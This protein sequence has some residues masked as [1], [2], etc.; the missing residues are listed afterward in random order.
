MT[1]FTLAVPEVAVR[2][3]PDI[4][5]LEVIQARFGTDAEVS[6]RLSVALGRVRSFAASGGTPDRRSWAVVTYPASGQVDAAI[7]LDAY[8]TTQGWEEYEVA[9]IAAQP[10]EVEIIERSV[11]R[12]DLPAGT[13]VVIHELLLPPASADVTAPATERTSIAIFPPVGGIALLLKA[14]TQDM[15]Q[16]EDMQAWLLQIAATV[17]ADKGAGT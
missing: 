13:A 16:F 11:D 4:D 14:T 1:A 12:A 10:S 15:L 7:T 2:L 6:K 5:N 3:D 9:A 17:A 8:A